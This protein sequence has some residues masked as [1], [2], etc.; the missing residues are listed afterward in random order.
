VSGEAQGLRGCRCMKRLR[1]LVLKLKRGY[2]SI[3]AMVLTRE[4][5]AARRDGPG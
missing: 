5:I 4:V 3:C 1:K 2:P